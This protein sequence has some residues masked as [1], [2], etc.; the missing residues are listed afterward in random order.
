LCHVRK[1]ASGSSYQK[2]ITIHATKEKKQMLRECTYGLTHF[3]AQ[4]QLVAHG[5]VLIGR[6]HTLGVVI[7][8]LSHIT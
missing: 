4:E 5:R 1:D 8:G 3:Y 6:N 2:N 7:L